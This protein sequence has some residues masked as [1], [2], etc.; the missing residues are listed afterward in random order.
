MDKLRKDKIKGKYELYK[1]KV[2]NHKQKTLQNILEK[3]EKIK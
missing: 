2:E 1:E 3:D